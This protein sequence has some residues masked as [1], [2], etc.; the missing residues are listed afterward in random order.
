MILLYLQN[1][2]EDRVVQ[3]MLALYEKTTLSHGS[4]N[5]EGRITDDVANYYDIDAT[6]L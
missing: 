5:P 3:F 4:K 2:T 1:L 6:L